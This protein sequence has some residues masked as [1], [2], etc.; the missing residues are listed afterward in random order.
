MTLVMTVLSLSVVAQKNYSYETV[1]GDP[2]SARIYTL[3]NGLKVYLAVVKERPRIQTYIAVR[4]GGKNDPAETTGLAHYLE[5]LMF[6]GTTRFGTSD[7]EKEAPYLEEITR[8]YEVYRKLTDPEERRRA[9]HEIDSVS[10]LAAQ[11]NIPNEYDKMMASIGSQGTNAYT[12][13]D[14]TCYTENIPSNEVEQWAKVQGERFQNMVIR[15]FHT[16]LEAVYEEYNISLASDSRKS[17]EKMM[18]ALY[19]THPYGTQTVIGTQDHLKNPS[20]VNIKNYFNK[21][22]VPNNTAVCMAGDFNPDEVI[23]VIDKYFGSWKPGRQFIEE[24]PLFPDQPKLTAPVETTVVGQEAENVMIGWA[25]DGAGTF[26]SDTLSVIQSMLANGK[27][28]LFDLNL[29]QKM[30]VLASEAFNYDQT[31][32]ST[33]IIAGMPNEGQSLQDVR[34]LLLGEVEKLKKGDFSDDL[35]P[36]VVNNFKLQFFRSL[37]SEESVA[38]RFVEAFV[39]QQ[40]WADI[41][42]QIDRISGMTKQQIMDFASRHFIDNYVCVYKEQGVDTTQKKIDK[43]AITAIPSNR[44]KSSDFLQE[45]VNAETPAIQPVFVDFKKDLTVTQTKKKLPVFYKHND[46]D[47]LFNLS[48]CFKM[49]IAADK[50]FQDALHY[51]QLVGTDKQTREQINQKLY[52]LACTFGYSLGDDVLRLNL[53][54]LN[55]NLPEALA[56]VEELLAHAQAD[57]DVYNQYVEQVLKARTDLKSDQRSCFRRLAE[58]GI[59]GPVN[60]YTDIMSEN[61]LRQTDPEDLL[62]LVKNLNKF[63]HTVLYYGPYTEKQLLTFLG[64]NHPVKK[65][66]PVKPCEPY[67]EQATPQNEVWIAPYEAKNIYM[68]SIHNEGKPWNVDETAVVN[69]FEEFFGGSMNAIVFQE[70]RESRG[71]AYSAS[72]GYEIPDRPGH[73]EYGWTYIISQNDKMMDCIHVFNQLLDDM[74]ASEPAF[75]LAKDGLRKQLESRRVTKMGVLNLYWNNLL[76]GIDYDLSEKIYQQL[77]SVTL[78]DVVNFEKDNMAH[79]PYRYLILGDEKELDMESLGKIGP[80]RRLALEEI[81]GY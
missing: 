7:A 26:Q 38:N 27:A 49:G 59:Y 30:K 42:G 14:V 24:K 66:Q 1:D 32:Y 62:Q 53:S 81:F 18:S 40:P 35:L 74:P 19:P 75:N 69:L 6:K 47:D 23:A 21:W 5:H 67:M 78:Q 58:Y 60:S 8:R 64:K 56:V 68:Q 3:D 29:N 12:S 41:V 65:L 20:I 39:N 80:I 63:E 28:G 61:E 50:R 31:D 57:R 15:G 48:F 72:A 37:D 25:F 52:R 51:L 16:E 71:L 36:S 10:Q 17:F 55:E 73:P 13:G 79:K 44:D 46:K 77:P 9:Y 76:Q 45:V 54:G 22:Y 4:T 33:F 43:P 11:Y 2:M 34:Q 70:L